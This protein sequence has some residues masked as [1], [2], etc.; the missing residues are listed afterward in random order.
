M[1]IGFLA[2]GSSKIGMG[3]IMRMSALGKYFKKMG[4]RVLFFSEYIEGINYLKNL[5]FDLVQISMDD[6]YKSVYKIS[7]EKKIDVIIA[8]YYELPNN[9]FKGIPAKI[10]KISMDD[11]YKEYP[12]CDIIINSNI[13]ADKSKY[14]TTKRENL[15]LG[16]D[17]LILRDEFYL[18]Q[19]KEM[20]KEVSRVMIT[21]GGTDIFDIMGNLIDSALKI[22][23][24]KVINVV[25]GNAFDNID[26]LKEKYSNTDRVKLLENQLMS[27][28][29]LKSDVAISASGSTTYELLCLNVPT[30][31]F[32]MIDNQI[33]LYNYIVKNELV[34][35]LGIRENLDENLTSYLKTFLKEET[36]E[37]IYEN[38]SRFTIGNGKENILSKIEKYKRGL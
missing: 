29:M 8:D 35:D 17:Y 18:N 11:I 30:A 37:R 38:C 6:E 3:H 23:D 9:F 15:W 26:A 33:D 31:S 28:L 5:K 22:E 24:F 25:I 27:E 4:H 32:M 13:F 20:P 16:K 21:T 2:N 7:E 10:L 19:K 34:F 12:D 14:K 1:R 36:L